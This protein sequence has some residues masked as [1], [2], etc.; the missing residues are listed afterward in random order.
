MR[1]LRSENAQMLAFKVKK[2]TMVRSHKQSRKLIQRRGV[3][4]VGVVTVRCAISLIR[5]TVSLNR[6]PVNLVRPELSLI[7][8]AV[9]LLVGLVRPGGQ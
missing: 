1:L 2:L 7:R 9:S 6:P 5:P 4:R 8:P 3:T